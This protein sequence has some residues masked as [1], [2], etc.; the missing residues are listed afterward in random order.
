MS[1]PVRFDIYIYLGIECYQYEANTN[2]NSK[3]SNIWAPQ[4]TFFRENN[5]TYFLV[6]RSLAERKNMEYS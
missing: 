1:T 2:S 3:Y 5:C 4:G 6:G